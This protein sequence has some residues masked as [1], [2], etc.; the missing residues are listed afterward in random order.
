MTVMNTYMALA[1]IKV[2]E[3]PQV[4]AYEKNVLYF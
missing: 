2:I 1:I 3:M 4:V